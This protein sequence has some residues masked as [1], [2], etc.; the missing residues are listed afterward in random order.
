MAAFL[1]KMDCEVRVITSYPYYPGWK[2]KTGMNH[3]KYAREI[4]TMDGKR[5]E[6]IRCPLWVPSQPTT[7]KRLLHLFSFALSSFPICLAQVMWKPDLILCVAPTILTA[8][9]ALLTAF[10]SGAKSWLHLQDFE[11]DAARSIGFFKHENIFIP[12][13]RS[14]FTGIIKQFNRIST[15]SEK[16]LEKLKKAGVSPEKLQL[17]P[18][19][20]N[21]SMV[22]YSSESNGYRKEVNLSSEDIVV[23]FSG[24]MTRKQSLNTVIEAARLLGSIK[25]IHFVICGEGVSR[26]EII[27]TSK[28]LSN[29]HFLPLQPAEKLNHLMNLADIHLLPQI[30]AAADLVLPS[31]ISAILASGR[32]LIATAEKG[33]AIAEL[34]ADAG[35]IIQPENPFIMAEAI[36]LL[37]GNS[38][39]RLKMG[40]HARTIA[41]K[42]FSA[43]IILHN[44]FAAVKS[45]EKGKIS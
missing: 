29:V 17:F 22:H 14:A 12:I 10:L 36:K 28:D 44:F 16:M 35:L 39:L 40:S 19:W 26:Q 2:V 6:V 32:P 11:I 5:C 8:P 13:I 43:E 24:S 38:E 18:N 41:E 21:L 3:R 23:L 37:A 9:T 31:K 30:A 1:T 25:N 45:L 27:E 33:T 42:R 34:V 15:I 20:V 7:Y 4:T